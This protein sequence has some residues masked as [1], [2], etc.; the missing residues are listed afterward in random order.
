MYHSIASFWLEGKERE[1]EEGGNLERRM[2][3]RMKRSWTMDMELK[4][5]TLSSSL[6]L[7]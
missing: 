3:C 2:K 1:K 5:Q 7:T 4:L 6:N